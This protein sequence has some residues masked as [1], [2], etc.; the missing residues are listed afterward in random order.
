MNIQIY[1]DLEDS[2]YVFIDFTS[3]IHAY[4]YAV[5]EGNQSVAQQ[6]LS[7][8]HE[9]SENVRIAKE[10]PIYTFLKTSSH[11]A[12]DEITWKTLQEA[13]L[14]AR[15]QNNSAILRSL[16]KVLGHWEQYVLQGKEWD[17]LTREVI[18]LPEQVRRFVLKYHDVSLYEIQR[19]EQVQPIKDNKE[20]IV[21]NRSMV[22]IG[23][24]RDEKTYKKAA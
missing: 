12:E 19:R 21:S 6:L 20:T 1:T 16:G 8:F 4:A 24:N 17:G 11:V 13:Y 3:L 15:L 22:E 23:Y 2:K 18:S 10:S 7:Y 9:E 5:K 14:I